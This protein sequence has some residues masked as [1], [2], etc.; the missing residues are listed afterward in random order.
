MALLMSSKT[1]LENKISAIQKYLT[2]LKRYTRFSRNNL[3]HDIDIRAAVERYLYLAI[4]ATIDCAEAVIAFKHFRKPT[5]YGE[6][7]SILFEQGILSQKNTQSLVRM[8]GF[9]N[10][11]AHDYEG[12]DYDIVYSMLHD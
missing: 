11:L 6:T 1:V 10:I 7:F 4:Q 2:F 9:R 12:I 5:T 8:C 3:E